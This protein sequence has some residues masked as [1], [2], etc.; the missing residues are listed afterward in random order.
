MQV[1]N[2]Y[3]VK[4]CSNLLQK[5]WYFERWYFKSLDQSRDTKLYLRLDEIYLGVKMERKVL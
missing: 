4:F 2:F 3:R 5:D 1:V